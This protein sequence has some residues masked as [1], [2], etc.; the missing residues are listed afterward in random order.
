M[1]KERPQQKRPLRIG[2]RGAAGHAPENTLASVRKAIEFGVDLV[3]V[4]VRR[5]RDGHLVLMHDETVDRTTN[6]K[7]KVATRSLADL[8]ALDA[9]KG[10]RIPTLEELLELAEGRVGLMLEIKEAGIADLTVKLVRKTGFTGTVVYASFLHKELPAV[11]KA[12]SEAATL[13]L[14][15]RRPKDP[16]A[17]AARVGVSHV[18]L[19]FTTATAQRV[20]ALHRAGLQVF[21]YTVNEPRD[22][23]A[24]RRLGVDGIISDFPDRL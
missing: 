6:G 4:D 11:R 7:G 9:G 24:M 14:F 21:V 19:R 8:Q 17:A 10:E 22:I 15:G 16:V 1:P 20:S 13:A 23:Q 18:G 12:D 5:S 3:E 2:H